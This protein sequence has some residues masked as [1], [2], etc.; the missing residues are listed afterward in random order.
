MHSHVSIGLKIDELKSTPTTSA[1][2]PLSTTFL[3]RCWGKEHK[4]WLRSR[5]EPSY[6][7]W[8]RVAERF[9]AK[10]GHYRTA[11]ALAS[12]ARRIGLILVDLEDYITL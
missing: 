1:M 12:Q 7:D 2:K 5:L 3:V 10:F 4:E 11:L 6:A 9:K 8:N